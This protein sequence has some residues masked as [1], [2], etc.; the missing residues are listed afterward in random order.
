MR[1]EPTEISTLAENMV[2]VAS[3]RMLFEC[4]RERELFDQLAKRY[5]A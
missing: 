3:Y 5:I 2:L 1:A 4:A